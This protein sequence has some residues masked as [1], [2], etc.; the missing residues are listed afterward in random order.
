M[1]AFILFLLF[2]FLMVVL[3]V[4]SFGLNV[5]R[6]IIGLFFPKRHTSES[7]VGGQG[8]SGHRDFGPQQES[9]GRNN[10]KKI[11]DTNEGEY[12]DFEEVGK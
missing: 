2:L 12:V 9:T 1:G 8:Y 7:Y 5:I 3:S 6:G 4:I 10:K 11:F